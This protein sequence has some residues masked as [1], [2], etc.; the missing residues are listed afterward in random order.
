MIELVLGGKGSGKTKV[1]LAKANDD[2][3]STGGNVVYMDSNNKLMYELNNRIRLLNLSEYNV[4]SADM[5][6][7]FIYGVVS[8]DHDLD[9]IF[10][11]N[12]MSIACIDTP[13]GVENLIKVLTD[14]SN[15]FEVDFV[16]GLS[17]KKEEL[18]EALQEMVTISL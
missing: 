4:S 8:Q 13:E 16:I 17:M 12:F 1:L 9:R 7:G 14:I 6:T 11:D 5:F 18:P 10:L 15:R 2:V 3:K